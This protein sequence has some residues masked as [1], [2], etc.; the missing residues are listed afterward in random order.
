M[1]IKIMR[2]IICGKVIEP[3][4]GELLPND[5]YAD[6]DDLPKKPLSFCQM[7]EAKIRHEA[8]GTHKPQKPI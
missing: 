8:D 5:P 2:C 6:E 1:A 4:E 3:D 7:C